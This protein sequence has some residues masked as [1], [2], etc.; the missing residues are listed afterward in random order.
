MKN[1]LVPALSGFYVLTADGELGYRDSG[2][3]F[4]H[5]AD[6][7]TALALYNQ[8]FLAAYLDRPTET[9]MRLG[10][11]YQPRERRIW[12]SETLA[13]ET[14]VLKQ[15]YGVSGRWIEELT[16]FQKRNREKSVYRGMELFLE[17]RNEN[18]PDAA[19]YAPV[20]FDRHTTLDQYADLLDRPVHAGDARTPVI[21]VINLLGGIPVPKRNSPW[22]YQP[23][24]ARAKS[25][26]AARRKRRR[27]SPFSNRAST[28]S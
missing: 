18:F 3:Q 12:G 6:L 23:L 1:T 24:T 5:H 15:L 17:H 27:R 28:M 14:A 9:G 21:E 26:T 19:V 7:S 11:V 2:G 22:A 25:S 13:L 4:V 16:E 8:K 20:L 10:I